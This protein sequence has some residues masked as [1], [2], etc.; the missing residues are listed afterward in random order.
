[1]T[2]RQCV[3]QAQA[4]EA[5]ALDGM[6]FAENLFT[7]GILPAA[8]CAVATSRMLIGAGVFNPSSRHRT[9]SAMDIGALDELS[10]GRV[11][12][13]LGSGLLLCLGRLDHP[14]LELPCR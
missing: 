6:A 3:A 5:A 12:L 1:M 7:R 13:P 2:S 14:A 4:A 8:A 11:G 10:H 9:L